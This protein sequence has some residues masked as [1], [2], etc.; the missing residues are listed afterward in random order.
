MA[1][2]MVQF[3][4]SAPNGETDTPYGKRRRYMRRFYELDSI[5]KQSWEPT[6][7]DIITYIQPNSGEFLT[8]SDLNRGSRKDSEILNDA[9]GDSSDKLVAAM[10]TGSTSEA[11]G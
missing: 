10:D 7:R 5:Y 11:R 4:A 8:D 3:S 2:A 1:E 9:G 6:H